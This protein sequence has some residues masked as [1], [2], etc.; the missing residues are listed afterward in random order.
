MYIRV[1][2]WPFIH[3]SQH[4]NYIY[5]YFMYILYITAGNSVQV[6]Y[7]V[8]PP[9]LYPLTL[10]QRPTNPTRGRLRT[11]G[12]RKITT[13]NP[14]RARLDVSLTSSYL[15]LSHPSFHSFQLCK[16]FARQNWAIVLGPSVRDWGTSFISLFG[17]SS[18]EGR[19]EA[20]RAV[21]PAFSAPFS[22]PQ[23]FKKERPSEFPPYHASIP[24][25]PNLTSPYLS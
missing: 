21:L 22:P 3:S 15:L 6:T 11:A 2:Y 17:Q 24:F 25:A 16:S 13:E 5:I 10:T 9:E 1:L 19:G 18:P 12:K 14:L 20:N 4:I 7:S 8:T 23:A